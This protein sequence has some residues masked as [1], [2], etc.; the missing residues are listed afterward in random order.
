[1]ADTRADARSSSG[2]SVTAWPARHSGWYLHFVF[3]RRVLGGLGRGLG[4]HLS[5]FRDRCRARSPLRLSRRTQTGDG[6]LLWRKPGR[7]CAYSALD[8][9][10]GKARHGGLAAM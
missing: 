10:A 8:I 7:H 9:S 5:E 6:Y 1:M 3:A 2:V 4:L